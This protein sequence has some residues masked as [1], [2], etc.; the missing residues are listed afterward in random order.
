MAVGRRFLI[1][2]IARILK[3]GCKADCAVILEGPQG[4]FKSIAVRALMPEA[5]WFTDE[6]AELGTKDAALQLLGR[7]IVEWSELDSMTRSEVSRVKAY[8][9]RRAIISARHM[10]RP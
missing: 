2:A 1:G 7:W 4:T 9:S 5:S 3:P 10:K 6:I 8:M